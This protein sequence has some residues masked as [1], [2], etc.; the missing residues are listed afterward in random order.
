MLAATASPF[1]DAAR[2][3]QP[4][5]RQRRAGLRRQQRRLRRRR[6]CRRAGHGFRG[7]PGRRRSSTWTGAPCA[8]AR[9]S[10][11]RCPTN[12]RRLAGAG[13]RPARLRAQ[14]WLPQRRA[15]PVRRHRLGARR[16][17]SPS[18]AF[19]PEQRRRRRDAVAGIRPRAFDR[20][21]AGPRASLG[22][23]F[24]VVPIEP[25]STTYL[26]HWRRAGRFAPGRAPD[27]A[28]A[29]A[30]LTEQN[31][32]AR[33]RGAM[34][35]AFS[36]RHN[37]LL[38]TTGNK[39]EV[40]VGYCTLYGDMC[41]GLAVISDVPK[42]TGVRAVARREPPTG[43]ERHPA[44]SCTSRRRPSCARTR[45]IRTRCRPTT[46]STRSSTRTWSKTS[47]RRR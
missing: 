36:N 2:V 7:R 25:T 27:V 23:D 31:L 16:R 3:R 44:S 33:V 18:R 22:I 35:M 42:T 26:E 6:Q 47:T 24:H 37:H 41:G 17:A 8:P 5:R 19:G 12:D 40:A 9:R 38:L 15:R 29:A 14:V 28:A 10:R 39:S 30:D 1:G 20:R 21:R 43:R 4:G 32:Q 13:A 34:L 45:P 11:P 46:C